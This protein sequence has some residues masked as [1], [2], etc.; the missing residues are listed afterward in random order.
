MADGDPLPD[1]VRVLS[2]AELASLPEPVVHLKG[3]AKRLIVGGVPAGLSMRGEAE[4]DREAAATERAVA[5]L[6]AA[7]CEASP[8]TLVFDGDAFE[9]R[10]F[11]C[12]VPRLLRARPE[13]HVC[14]FML[15]VPQRVGRFMS[16]WTQPLAGGTSCTLVLVPLPESDGGGGDTTQQ[17]DAG[18]GAHDAKYSYLGCEA[19][20]AT[21]ASDV[22][23]LGGGQVL[24]SEFEL[25]RQ[26]S[27]ARHAD[28]APRFVHASVRRQVGEGGAKLSL[29]S[30]TL[31]DVEGVVQI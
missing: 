17:S 1:N 11:T 31:D 7:I 9:E 14:A 30:S 2:L 23:C 3:F 19:L 22:F 24:A 8:R 10:S 18:G 6:C 5:R 26:R 27:G 29:E 13:M 16:T 15:D 12:V 4:W 28:A 21:G 25:T 20:L